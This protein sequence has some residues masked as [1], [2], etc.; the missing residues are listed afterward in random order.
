[1]K[2]TFIT[3]SETDNLKKRLVE[4]I[5]A[6]QEL[7]FLIGFFY[8]SGIEQLHD[9]L[10]NN[11]NCSLKILVG[12]DIDQ[13]IFGLTEYDRK[14]EG[15]TQSEQ[16]DEYLAQITKTLNTDKY[17]SKE[18]YERIEFYLELI[19]SER[20]I[21]RKTRNPNHAKLYIFKIKDGLGIVRDSL[22]IT[23]SSNL[24]KSGIDSQ[25]EFNIEISDY[26]TDK[27][28]EYFDNL[29]T[30]A[31]HF[32]EKPEFKDR[33]IQTITKDTQVATI[34]PFQAFV[35]VLKSYLDT[36]QSGE[37]KESIKNLLKRKGYRA[38][39]YQSDAIAQA[40]KQI[41]DPQA[42]NGII[43]SDVVGL[44]KS[45]I[46]SLVGKSLNE[47]GIIISPPGLMGD[48]N[49]RT[50]WQK[51][52]EDFELHGWEIRSNHPEGPNGLR[53]TL[54]L[55]RKN[56]EYGVIIVDEAHRFRN[57]STESYEL[58][59]NICRGKKVILLTATPFNNQP[60]D[61]F[62]L[63]KLFVRP[64]QSTISLD[65]DIT[66][67]FKQYGKAFDDISFIHKN[68]KSIDSVK[69]TKS[70]TLYH[71]LIGEG[72][73]DITLTKARAKSLGSEIRHI[74]EPIIIRR[75]RLD[76]KK[77]PIYSKEIY[78]L[79]EFN[80]PN[81]ILYQLSPDQSEFYDYIIQECFAKDEGRF[82]G[83][84]YQPFVYEEGITKD[85]EISVEGIAAN[86]E[87]QMQLNL[88]DFMR[89]MIIKRFESSFYAFQRTIERL[90]SL[91]VMALKFIDRS[92]QK[93]VLDRNF[94]STLQDLDEDEILNALASYEVELNTGKYPS[95]NKIY[96]VDQFKWHQK[97]VS[98]IQ[99]DIDLFDEILEKVK[100]LN[101]IENDPKVVAISQQVKTIIDSGAV[102][103]EPARKVIVFS[104]YSDTVTHIAKKLSATFSD[105][106]I[107]VPGD[108]P[109]SKIDTILRNFDAS[110]DTQENIF[111]ILV[112]T[113]KLAEGFNLARAG[114]VINYDIPWNPTRVIQ[115]LGRINRIGQRVFLF[116]DIYNCFPTE[117]GAEQ[118]KVRE[119]AMEK[120]FLIHN[121]L[122]EDSQIFDVSEEPTP[123][124]LYRQLMQSPDNQ[125]EESF[126]TRLRRL[127]QDISTSHPEIIINLTKL[128]P[129]LKV[130]KAGNPESLDVFIKKGIGLYIRS[131]NDH[132]EVSEPS[133]EQI[134]ERIECEISTPNLPLSSHFWS[135][136]DLANNKKLVAERGA[137]SSEISAQVKAT[138]ILNDLLGNTELG[139]TKRREFILKLR[140]DL[141]D[142]KS[143][144]DYTIQQLAKLPVEDLPNT[145]KALDDLSYGLGPD[146]GVK[147]ASTTLDP[148]V[149]V[150]IANQSPQK[151]I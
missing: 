116:L 144:P 90:H 47:R 21:I 118:F 147:I 39:Q 150:A 49:K 27:A 36:L 12:L 68:Y 97:F 1:M 45:I 136:Y 128:P 135:D 79:S 132:G 76:L 26:G 60:T 129:R 83:A 115:R 95:K 48:S 87:L 86:Q 64:G 102:G 119:I 114:A 69:R 140:E 2:N 101:L 24:T 110:S 145:I 103:Q 46:A 78:E 18:A 41:T 92:D 10:K 29:W 16:F 37:I 112:T 106:L 44:G 22:F 75:N 120:M 62:S 130:A 8:F 71:K 42:P 80:P 59:S 61:I 113:D 91:H 3:N 35:Y 32:T 23:G 89:H 52:R 38:Y 40:V 117:Q 51:Y 125:E 133:F 50:G 54:E 81:E 66:F 53:K 111:Q 141:T 109:S 77:D 14:R 82:Y 5:G 94:M 55:V 93:F 85:G 131:I 15:L 13:G 67:K 149:I 99:S 108:L 127:M 151:K 104:E 72:P 43:I 139:I 33:L 137:T 134:F 143:L 6:S 17:D 70:Q 98:D 122:G 19:K 84:I 65:N 57:Q 31:T 25:E 63:L 9:S 28:N 124:G 142:I 73:I 123:A 7:K 56:D 148:T 100:K 105:Q 126:V 88:Y 107:S 121:T 96:Q 11:P 34:T 146:F 4:L 58:L 138:N 20:L 30:D 74:I